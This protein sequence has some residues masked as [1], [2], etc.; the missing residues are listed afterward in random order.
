MWSDSAADH[1]RGSKWL[2][3]IAVLTFSC[4]LPAD[5]FVR[6]RNR[7]VIFQVSCHPGKHCKSAPTS[8]VEVRDVQDSADPVATILAAA[9]RHQMV[10]GMPVRKVRGHPPRRHY[11]GVFWS[12]PTV[13]M[14]SR[15]SDFS[16]TGCGWRTTHRK[17][18]ICW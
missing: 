12:A 6:P 5:I 17:R 13:V 11:A 2:I 7:R 18:W 10:R 1:H 14:P 3:L 9:D 16:W 8:E 15:R 4:G